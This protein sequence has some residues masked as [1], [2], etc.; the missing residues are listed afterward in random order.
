[1]P[2]VPVHQLHAKAVDPPT[3]GE[4]DRL[5]IRLADRLVRSVRRKIERPQFEDDL[6]L[7]L[8]VCDP[9][10]RRTLRPHLDRQTLEQR[11]T[12]DETPRQRLRRHRPPSS[13]IDRTNLA[14]N[15]MQPR[16][17]TTPAVTPGLHG[18][19]RH[20]VTPL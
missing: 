17:R 6:S 1:R 4:L 9:E 13:L 16:L 7:R 19:R 18:R 8:V 3:H 14:A 15:A 10:R 5:R 20:P 2:A 11:E 12:D